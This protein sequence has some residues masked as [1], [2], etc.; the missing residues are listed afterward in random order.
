MANSNQKQITI[1]LQGNKKILFLRVK[2]CSRVF[3]RCV[4]LMFSRKA[5]QKKLLFPFKK[6]VQQGFHMFFVFYSID[7]LFLDSNKQIVDIKQDFK[8]FSWYTPPVKYQYALEVPRG[9]VKEHGLQ[10]GDVLTF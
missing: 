3:S 2:V 7:L 1:T 9:G 10:V 5:S 4:G 8:P 6:E